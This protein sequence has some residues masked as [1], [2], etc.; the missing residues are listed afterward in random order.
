V[1]WVWP[2]ETAAAA[3]VSTAPAPSA[4]APPNSSSSFPKSSLEVAAVDQPFSL[5]SAAGKHASR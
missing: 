1:E 3:F 2:L 5:S 4:A